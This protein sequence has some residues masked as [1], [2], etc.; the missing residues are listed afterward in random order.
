MSGGGGRLVIIVTLCIAMLLTILPMPDWARPFRP[1]W[2]TLVML[3]WAIALPHRVGV[4][5]GFVAGIMLDVL[6]GTLLGQHALGLSVVTFVAIQLHQRIRV[7]PFWQQSLGILILLVIEHLL[8]LWVTGA[9]RGTSPGL[10][11]W[12][13]PLIGALLWPWVFVTL[14]KV[15]RHFKVS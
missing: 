15:R 13:V 10:I 8:A 5:S 7:F 14:R 3:Y 9:T 4:G 2:V 6:T 1:Q 12:S 11:Y